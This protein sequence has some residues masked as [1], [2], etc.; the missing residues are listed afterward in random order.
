MKIIDLFSGCGGFSLGF[1]MENF[2]PCLAVEIDRWASETYSYN[3]PKIPVLTKDIRKIDPKKLNLNK[4]D[5]II[6]GPPCQGFSLSGNRDTKDPR[7]SLFID[8]V[9][10]VKILQPKF[11]VMEN[12]KGLLSMKTKKNL[13]VKD[14]ILEEFNKI[15]Y[16]VSLQVLTSAN[17][18]V[19]QVRERVFFIGVREDLPFDKNK[20]IPK[21]DFS[22]KQY[23]KL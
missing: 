1:Q 14:I 10:F 19:P 16:N 21:I 20:L 2:K 11:F 18:G 23:L 13:L 8:F 15:K 12:V 17:Y 22:K 3:H 7:N 9:R 6:G 4:I 5:G